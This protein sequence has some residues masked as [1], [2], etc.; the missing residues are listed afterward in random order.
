MRHL[1]VFKWPEMLEVQALA[2]SIVLTC[3]L[4][5][6]LR[7][8]VAVVL[9]PIPAGVRRACRSS[10]M[11]PLGREAVLLQLQGE[12]G[13]GHLVVRYSAAHHPLEGY[14]CNAAYVDSSATR[15]SPYTPKR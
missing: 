12:P 8:G 4:M 13:C 11:I 10:W 3:F 2:R 7:Y 9:I 5:L 14:V 15:L 1:L 6:A